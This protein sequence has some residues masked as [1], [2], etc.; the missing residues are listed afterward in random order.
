MDD[1][2]PDCS[3]WYYYTNDTSPDV[4][5]FPYTGEMVGKVVDAMKR[6]CVDSRFE[7]ID[8]FVAKPILTVDD[9]LKEWERLLDEDVEDDE[10]WALMREAIKRFRTEL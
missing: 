3:P 1:Y 4:F 6:Y 9:V 2:S 7:P 10:R 8:A 5:E